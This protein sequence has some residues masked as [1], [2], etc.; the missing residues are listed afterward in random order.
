TSRCRQGLLTVG[1]PH[2]VRYFSQLLKAPERGVIFYE[3]SVP[4]F[5]NL[6][7]AGFICFV[8]ISDRKGSKAVLSVA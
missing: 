5:T 3:T 8:K 6:L 1:F 7:F 4:N 2:C